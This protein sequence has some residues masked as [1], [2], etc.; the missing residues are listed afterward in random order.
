[1]NYIRIYNLLCE[2][3]FLRFD[4]IYHSDAKKTI[5]FYVERH[6][7]L[8]GC[9]GGKYVEGNV[10]WLTPEEHMVAHELLTKIY[11]DNR[12][13]IFAAFMMG[14]SDKPP[15]CPAKN[16]NKVYGWLRRRYSIVMSNREVKEETKQKHRDYLLLNPMNTP[17]IQEKRRISLLKYYES[18]ESASKG[19]IFSEEQKKQMSEDRIRK[20]TF[21]GERNPMYG[22][23]R[24]NEWRADQ[25]KRMK[26]KAKGKKW[27]YFEDKQ[28]FCFPGQQPSNYKEGVS[29]ITKMKQRGVRGKSIAGSKAKKGKN[30]PN[31]GKRK[32]EREISTG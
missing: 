5:P 26:G 14:T 27:Y 16:K 10:A 29:E 2:R 15:Q 9:M 7:I 11:P 19:F 4:G 6:R 20:G 23:K 12:D 24:S 1:M 25:S 13:L 32:Y 18:H 3:G 8:P 31:Y 30:N 22:K 28:V 21:K 17:E